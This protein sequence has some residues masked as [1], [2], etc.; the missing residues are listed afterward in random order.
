MASGE[1][2]TEMFI[3]YQPYRNGQFIFPFSETPIT[4]IEFALE[5][6]ERLYKLDLSNKYEH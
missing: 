6:K 1:G 2:G 4:T 3:L 5:P